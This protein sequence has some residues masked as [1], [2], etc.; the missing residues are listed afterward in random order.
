M[1]LKG[2]FDERLVAARWEE[3]VEASYPEIWRFCA[4]LTSDAAADD[5]AQETFLRATRALPRF[6]GEA[7]QSTWLLSI[8]RNVCADHLR[9]RY[10]RERGEGALEPRM[11]ADQDPSDSV[12]ARDLIGRLDGDRRAAFVLTQL[13]GLTYVEAAAVCDCPVGT[14]RSRVARASEDLIELMGD[15]RSSVADAG[16]ARDR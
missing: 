10:R 7:S 13:Y 5:L 9:R 15:P 8:A 11:A 6:R 1:G 3:L 12:T 2:S 14:I 4:M 16:S